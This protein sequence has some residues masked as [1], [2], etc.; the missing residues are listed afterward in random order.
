MELGRRAMYMEESLPAFLVCRTVQHH[1]QVPPIG[2]G[3]LSSLGGN[4]SFKKET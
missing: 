4:F 1:F 2:C 3:T